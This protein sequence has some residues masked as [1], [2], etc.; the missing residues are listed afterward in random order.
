MTRSWLDD[1]LKYEALAESV[2]PA[3]VLGSKDA[4]GW[5][6]LWWV[7]AVLSLG[8]LAALVPLRRFLED[9]ASGVAI[10]VG[11]PPRAASIGFRWLRHELRH[12]TQFVA[13]GYLVPVLGWLPLGL[14]GR[15]V[16]AVV[17]VLPY[18][19]VY[20]LG[21]PLPLG[22]ALGRYYLERD[23]EV[24]AWRAG[25]AD[26]SL[27]PAYVRLRAETFGRLLRG[28]AYGFACPW[29]VRDLR[30]AAEREVERFTRERARRS[31]RKL[32]DG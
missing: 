32:I 27:T 6:A 13:F 12:V 15:R 10:W 23:A 31:L 9:F 18:A 30:R 24:T 14:L 17:G 11:F 3:A 25:L 16:R 20:V 2:E 26:G 22:L 28:R 5:R 29:A 8:V 19:V 4:P 21:L 7:G 1:K